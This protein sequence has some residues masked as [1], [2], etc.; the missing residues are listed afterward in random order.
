MMGIATVGSSPESVQTTDRTERISLPG[1][2]VILFLSWIGAIP[3][4]LA[5]RGV[6]L[7]GPLN[8]L[9]LLMLFGPAMAACFVSWR[10]AGLAGVRKLLSGLLKARNHPALYAAVLAG[11]AVVFAIALLLSNAAGLTSIAFPSAAKFLSSFGMT[12]GVYFL[13]NTEEL[14]WRGYALPRFQARMGVLP[15]TLVLSVLWILFH[16]PLFWMKDGHPAGYPFWL[17]SLMIL[18][19]SLP[20]TALYN[21]TG[22][23]ILMVHLLHQ[24][25]NAS[26]EALPIFPAATHSLAPISISVALC[27]IVSIL[28]AIRMRR[29]PSSV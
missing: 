9:Q 13:L 16:L 7:P 1:F 22:G 14:A 28:L 3:M 12:L 11:P 19:I 24:S 18:G 21:S 8:G 4:V 6:R 10:N 5:S 29:S 20:F 27:V 23:S 25:F 26:V 15:A 17:F 2:F